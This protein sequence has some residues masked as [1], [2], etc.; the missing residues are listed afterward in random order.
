MM[1]KLINRILNIFNRP[2]PKRSPKS[3]LAWQWAQRHG[4]RLIK[5]P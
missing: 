2:D 3:Y 1:Q 5:L 4:V